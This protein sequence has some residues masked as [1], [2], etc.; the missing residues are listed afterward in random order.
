[1]P[2][3]QWDNQ[4]LQRG[5]DLLLTVATG[6]LPDRARQQML[7]EVAQIVTVQT[8]MLM[9]GHPTKWSDD[10]FDCPH[11]NCAQKVTVTLQKSGPSSCKSCHNPIGATASTP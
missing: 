4:S 6:N 5:A 2:G 9:T 3:Q 8:M 1:M 10:K 7:D 11:P